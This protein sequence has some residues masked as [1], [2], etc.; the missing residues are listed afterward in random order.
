MFTCTVDFPKGEVPQFVTFKSPT[1]EQQSVTLS[2]ND[3]R[4]Q[5]H[6]YNLT[7][8]AHGSL[9]NNFSNSKLLIEWFETYLIL[10][11]NKFAVYNHSGSVFLKPVIEHYVQQGVLD[12]YDIATPLEVKSLRQGQMVIIQDCIY[13]YM[14]DTKYLALI[15]FDEFFYPSEKHKHCFDA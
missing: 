11:A 13:R 12:F 10:G 4:R 14:Y 8:C 15:D 1:S 3:D 6:L 5:K 9:R 2:V 7:I